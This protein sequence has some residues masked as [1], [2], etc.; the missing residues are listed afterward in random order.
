V[1]DYNLK[2]LER[3]CLPIQCV[4]QNDQFIHA[5]DLSAVSTVGLP[6]PSQLR[7]MQNP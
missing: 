7:S 2:V 3:K 4:M 6:G 1:V 5:N